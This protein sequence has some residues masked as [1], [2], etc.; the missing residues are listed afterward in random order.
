MFVHHDDD[1]DIGHVEDYD[2]F[3]INHGDDYDIDIIVHGKDYDIDI[4]DQVRVDFVDTSL[5]PPVEGECSLQV[6]ICLWTFQKLANIAQ[7]MH[8]TFLGKSYKYSLI[9]SCW[10]NTGLMTML[11]HHL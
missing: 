9:D 5:L 8:F 6:K 3:I 11:C 2:I 7:T 1:F 4:I 10:K